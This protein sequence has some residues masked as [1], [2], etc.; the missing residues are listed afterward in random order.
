MMTG[1][2]NTVLVADEDPAV[3]TEIRSWLVG[4]YRIEAT[5]DGDDALAALADV[6]VVLVGQGLRT[7]AGTAVAAEVEH[8]AATGTLCDGE[9]GNT[10]TVAGETLV[11][12]LAKADLRETVDRLLRR[13]RYDELMA[14]CATLAA[15]RGT[16]EAR[17]NAD[18]TSECD[19]E[20]AALERRLEA[21][22]SDLDELVASF[23]RDDFRA[24]FETCAAGDV[25]PSERA[26]ELS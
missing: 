8:R 13:A 3:V 9:R 15:K 2:T 14:E 7:A 26:G 1:D 11:K 18:P 21:V 12:P 25:T 23:D 16:L 20:Y 6:D 22:F 24:A 5:T 17:S 4:D 10:S 19:A